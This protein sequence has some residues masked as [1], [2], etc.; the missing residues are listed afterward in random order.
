MFGV[1]GINSSD[2][3]NASDYV[4]NI[5]TVPLCNGFRE[6]LKSLIIMLCSIVLMQDLIALA[7]QIRQRPYQ[8]T[9]LLNFNY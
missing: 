9:N 1:L 6:A 3:H 2:S 5:L 7:D 8:E 4:R